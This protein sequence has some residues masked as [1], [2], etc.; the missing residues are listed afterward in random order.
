MKCMYFSGYTTSATGPKG[1][2]RSVLINGKNLVVGKLYL[3][4]DF[5]SY[6]TREGNGG[7]SY[8]T[9]SLNYKVFDIKSKKLLSDCERMSVFRDSPKKLCKHEDLVFINS[10]SRIQQCRDCFKKFKE[11]RKLVRVSR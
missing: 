7:S 1:E 10:K 6:T 8:S 11:I 4:E 3:V 2:N 9:S 5:Y